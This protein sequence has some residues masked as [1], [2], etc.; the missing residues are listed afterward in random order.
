VASPTSASVLSPR[1]CAFVRSGPA[2]A[3]RRRSRRPLLGEVSLIAAQTDHADQLLREA[4]RVSREISAVSAEALASVRLGEAVRARGPP[5][6]GDAMLAD[7]LVLSR[8][9]PLGLVGPKEEQMRKLMAAG[10]A[11]GALLTVGGGPAVA[12]P[13]DRGNCISSRDNDGAAGE[14]VSS[15]AGPGFGPAV[16]D[17][18]GG[19]VIGATARDPDCR[20][21]RPAT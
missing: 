11:T 3:A 20:G 16:A 18:I 5:D 14:R 10:L 15:A 2:R 12:A 7:A 17:A 6:E 21:H 8:W 1:S 13:P 4:V 19:G 9:S